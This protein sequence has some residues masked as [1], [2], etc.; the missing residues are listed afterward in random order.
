MNRKQQLKLCSIAEVHRDENRKLWLEL[1]KHW[2]FEWHGCTWN[3]QEYFVSSDELETY[4]I[5]NEIPFRI[6]YE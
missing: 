2:K 1:K 4:C 3:S 6:E 5:L